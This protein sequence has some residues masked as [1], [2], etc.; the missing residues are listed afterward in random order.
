[1]PIRPVGVESRN[2]MYTP[3]CGCCVGMASLARNA[4]CPRHARRWRSRGAGGLDAFMTAFNERTAAFERPSTS[5]RAPGSRGC[6]I[7]A[8][9]EAER[10]VKARWQVGRLAW[11]RLEV[12]TPGGQ[13]AHRHPFPLWKEVG[14]GVRSIYVVNRETAMGVK[15]SELRAIRWPA[16]LPP[17]VQQP[18]MRSP[19]FGACCTNWP[20]W[21]S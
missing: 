4:T 21:G 18:T 10:S 11:D 6:H 13:G 17:G 12:I 9:T 7:K 19:L 8:A 16:L 2:L 14:V 15:I 20:G 5:K 1:M 3:Q